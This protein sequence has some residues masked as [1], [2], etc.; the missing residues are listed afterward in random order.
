MERIQKPKIRNYKISFKLEHFD[1]NLLGLRDNNLLG[2]RGVSVKKYHNFLVAR[3]E[4]KIVYTIFNTSGF[5][6]ATGIKTKEECEEAKLFLTERLQC[7]AGIFKIDN[8]C[9]SGNFGRE[10]DLLSVK[11][12]FLKL[13]HCFTFNPDQFAGASLKLHTTPGCMIIFSTG[14]FSILG[15]REEKDIENL[16]QQVETELIRSNYGFMHP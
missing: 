5:V 1:N 2:L 6:N 13:K 9:A 14:S 8:I 15:V 10:I 4:K 16:Y 7:R 11:K 3:S 12:T